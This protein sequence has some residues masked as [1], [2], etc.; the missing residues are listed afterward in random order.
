M[1]RM[2]EVTSSRP[3]RRGMA[4]PEMPVPAP[5]ETSGTAWRAHARTTAR[6]CASVWGSTAS[7]GVSRR[8]M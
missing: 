2:R 3:S 4:P 8:A 7:I 6:T 5:R 1:A